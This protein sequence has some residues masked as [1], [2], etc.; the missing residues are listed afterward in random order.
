MLTGRSGMYVY[1]QCKGKMICMRAS[2]TEVNTSG[3]REWIMIFCSVKIISSSCRQLSGPRVFSM[4]RKLA[5]DLGQCQVWPAITSIFSVC[6]FT[7]C[8]EGAAGRKD[9]FFPKKGSAIYAHCKSTT[10]YQRRSK[11]QNV[12]SGH[13]WVNAV[14]LG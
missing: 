1:C 5:P 7:R 14:P 12:F 9:T 4:F 3:R 6:F 10:I 13:T 2:V 8:Q 11:Q